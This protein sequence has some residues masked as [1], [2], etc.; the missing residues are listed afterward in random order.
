MQSL[1]ILL[2]CLLA[3]SA[4]ATKRCTRP[5]WGSEIASSAVMFADFPLTGSPALNLARICRYRCLSTASCLAYEFEANGKAAGDCSLFTNPGPMIN[6]GNT[7][8]AAGICWY[9]NNNNNNNNNNNDNNN[10]NDVGDNQNTDSIL[11]DQA[12]DDV[13][14][15]PVLD[16]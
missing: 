2:V 16:P 13:V 14:G 8:M 9:P 5:R 10:A 4:A 11:N 1:F 6:T 12:P 7:R 15:P 3:H